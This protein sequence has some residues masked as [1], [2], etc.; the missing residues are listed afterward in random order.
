MNASRAGL[1]SRELTWTGE[2]EIILCCVL[3]WF[4][5][6]QYWLDFVCPCVGD[7][8]FSFHVKDAKAQCAGTSLALQVD[9]PLCSVS[10]RSAGCQWAFLPLASEESSG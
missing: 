1:Y 4:C 8:N 9:A 7:K 2:E 6:S 3:S 5:M 10:G